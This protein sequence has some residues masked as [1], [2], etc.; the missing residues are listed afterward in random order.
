MHLYVCLIFNAE[1]A[2]VVGAAIV[3]AVTKAD[4]LAKARALLKDHPSA[5]GF[6]L[7]LD[8]ERVHAYFPG[9]NGHT[10]S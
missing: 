1:D 9:R 7:W 10:A 5:A 2:V 3:N 8:G 6:E 4:A